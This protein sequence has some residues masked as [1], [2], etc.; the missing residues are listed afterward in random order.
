[1]LDFTRRLLIIQRCNLIL[2]KSHHIN[3]LLWRTRLQRC[4]SSIGPL[5]KWGVVGE[6]N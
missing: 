4:D 1:M 6:R 2:R 3:H 5:S